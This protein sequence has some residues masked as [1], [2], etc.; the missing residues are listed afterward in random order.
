MTLLVIGIS[1]DWALYGLYMYTHVI[2]HAC[3][4]V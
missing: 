3:V 4:H 2:V 1:T